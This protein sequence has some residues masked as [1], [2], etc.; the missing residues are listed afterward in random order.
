MK[1]AEAIQRYHCSE[2]N[3]DLL[4]FASENNFYGTQNIKGVKEGVITWVC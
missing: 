1:K 3:I 4:F 2:N